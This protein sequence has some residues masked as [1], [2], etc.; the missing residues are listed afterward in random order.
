[1]YLK[2]EKDL[3]EFK[4]KTK[5]NLF[6]YNQHRHDE[7]VRFEFSHI[8]KLLENRVQSILETVD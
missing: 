8:E 3:E 5:K 6:D 7:E 1:M 4:E 2:A